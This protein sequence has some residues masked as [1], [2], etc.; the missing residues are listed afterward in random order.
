MLT[1]MAFNVLLTLC[2]QPESFWG[3]PTKAMRCDGLSIYAITNHTFDFF[4]GYG[5]LPF[6]ATNL[7]YIAA[8]VFA[9]SRLPR[10]AA[11][12]AIFAVI[13]AHGYSA[14]NWLVVRFHFGGGPGVATCGTLL[15]VLLS[16]A[17]LPTWDRSREVVKVWRWL[18]VAALFV[19]FTNTLLGQ[20]ASYWQDPATMHESNALTR[21]FLGRGWIYY[22]GLDLILA[23]GQFALITILPLPVA[24]VCVFAFIFGSFVGASNWFFY[25][26]RLGWSAPIAY[27]TI[28]STLIVLLA[29][30]KRNDNGPN[31]ALMPTPASVT[32]AAGAPVAPDAGAAHL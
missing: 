15:G 18:M 3:D 8:A 14:T 20:P 10:I 17:I 30:R 13:F 16:F 28:L 11:L 1:A 6:V 7:L 21:M 29:F 5:P 12:I 9:V 23:A 22:L 27:G 31:Q 24:F 2:G 25:E 26:W 32:P 19:D 4:L